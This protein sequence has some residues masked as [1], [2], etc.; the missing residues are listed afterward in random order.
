VK[1]KIS[2]IGDPA[3][4]RRRNPAMNAI[5]PISAPAWQKRSMVGLWR[6]A[7]QRS[8]L[9]N[10]GMGRQSDADKVPDMRE[11][12]REVGE[13]RDIEAYEGLFRHFAPR[14]KAYM[15]RMG[16][17]SKLAEELMQVTM[18]LVW[19][20][21]ERYDTSKGAASTWI[22]TIARNLR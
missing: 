12:L 5:A 8:E 13:R 1:G 16:G 11:L 3:A 19:S 9:G 22:F 14:V 6:S 17:D 10:I 21:A 4:G 7:A 15:A 2:C 18:I 20:K